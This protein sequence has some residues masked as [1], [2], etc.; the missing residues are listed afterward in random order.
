[1]LSFSS[2]GIINSDLNITR[3]GAA[4]R[5]LCQW[6]VVTPWRGFAQDVPGI[7]HR[8]NHQWV[9]T[10]SP[11]LQHRFALCMISGDTEW[12][13]DNCYLRYAIGIPVQRNTPGPYPSEKELF[14]QVRGS[15]Y[16]ARMNST[17]TLGFARRATAYKRA[18]LLFTDLD[19]RSKSREVGARYS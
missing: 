9:S 5:A 4:A 3:A 1:M 6:S 18:D 19:R 12:R 16:S 13:R 7:R 8:R 14:Q 11:G 10:P 17:F 2:L 15:R